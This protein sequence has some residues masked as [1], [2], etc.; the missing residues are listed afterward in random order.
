[1]KQNTTTQTTQTTQTQCKK[2]SLNAEFVE[3]ETK[4]K[5]DSEEAVQTADLIAD[6]TSRLGPDLLASKG[7][8]AGRTT[9]H[10]VIGTASS[11]YFII[12]RLATRDDVQLITIDPELG[13]LRYEHQ[14]HHDLFDTVEDALEHITTSLGL[15]ITYRCVARALLGYAALGAVGCLLVATQVAGDSVLPGGHVVYTIAETAWIRVPLRITLPEDGNEQKN[16]DSLTKFQL[17]GLHYYCETCDLTQG[18]PYSDDVYGHY[19]PSFAWNEFLSESFARHGLREWCPVL[20]Q[21]TCRCTLHPDGI[22]LTLVAK[23]CAENPGTRY[24][25]RGMNARNSPGNE[26]E[27]ELVVWTG[28][29]WA[30]YAWRRGTVPIWW[31]SEPPKGVGDSD[32]IVRDNEP[33]AGCDVY[34]NGVMER[35]G[36]PLTI[37]NLLAESPLKRESFL[38]GHFK[39]AIEGV[40]EANGTDDIKLINYDWH[41]K[42]K[43]LGTE[44]NVETLWA[45]LKD[46]FEASGISYGSFA[47]QGD[48]G[49]VDPLARGTRFDVES[50]QNGVCRFNCADSL[51]RTNIVTFFVCIQVLAEMCWALKIRGFEKK[52]E[53]KEPEGKKEEKEEKKEEKKEEEEKK[54]PE[55]NVAKKGWYGSGMDYKTLANSLSGIGLL[56]SLS[57]A[58]SKHKNKH[59]QPF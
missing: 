6:V 27:C 19:N 38:S 28:A 10:I 21:G 14:Q 7:R 20:L 12:S 4:R 48:P 46:T 37:V 8:K 45:A 13:T 55:E 54:E 50:T 15:E 30:R 56:C 42:T 32:I 16:I 40:N 29:R 53:E 49:K 39:K 41:A 51:D 58:F 35:F 9:Q 36:R 11:E 52:K 26:L 57:D 59:K 47:S 43:E 25:A 44:G 22:S 18:F 23:K 5:L 17:N 33:Y 1:M 34:M 3:G 2:I 31:R 24:N